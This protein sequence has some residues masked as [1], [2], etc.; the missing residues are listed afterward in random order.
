MSQ[1]GFT[2]TAQPPTTE[3]LDYLA[4]IEAS[5]EPDPKCRVCHGTRGKTG[6][7]VETKPDGTR[8]AVLLTCCLKPKKNGYVLL[9]K[10]M[11]D[12]AHDLRHTRHAVMER[13]HD[14]TEILENATNTIIAELAFLR[15]RL[16]DIERLTFWGGIQCAFRRLTG[17]AL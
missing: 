9:S 6:I 10:H 16:N 15:A 14:S 1:D 4:H 17:R 8:R 12:T 3:E 13:V 7:A 2:P 11:E 5:Y